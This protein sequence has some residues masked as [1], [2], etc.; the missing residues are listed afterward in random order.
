M[1]KHT[2]SPTEPRTLQQNSRLH[3]LLGQLGIDTEQRHEL[4]LQFTHGRT[5]SSR[6]MLALECNQLIHSLEKQYE[7]GEGQKQYNMR[8]KVFSL[9]HELGW[10]LPDGKVN[11]DHLDAFILKRGGT[12]K[13]F[14]KLSTKDLR[15]LIT[16]LEVMNAK[17][18][19]NG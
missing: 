16:Q 14:M 5:H 12:K 3:V 13:P 10:E 2:Y 15:N 19:P 8:R 6:A 9:A 7:S 1:A 11:R 18:Q 17:Q 4:V